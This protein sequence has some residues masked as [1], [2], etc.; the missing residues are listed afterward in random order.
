MGWPPRRSGR[1][2]PT[3]LSPRGLAAQ[4]AVTCLP[5]LQRAFGTRAVP[6]I[7]GLLILGTGLVFFALIEIEKQMRL[8]LRRA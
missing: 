2:W 8:A 4:F 5:S 3:G 7:D 6:L 1:L